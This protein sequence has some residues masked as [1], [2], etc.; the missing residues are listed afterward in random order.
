MN[1]KRVLL[2]LLLCFLD[3]F[4]CKG[5]KEWFIDRGIKAEKIHELTWW[6][7]YPY[8]EDLKMVCTPCQHW[9]KRKIHQK[10]QILQRSVLIIYSRN[11][12]QYL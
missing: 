4:V 3:Y 8:S 12:N 9:T 1:L 7:S 11:I 6:E 10:I 2:L 5:M